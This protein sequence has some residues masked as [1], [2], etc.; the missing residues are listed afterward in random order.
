MTVFSIYIG[1]L[2]IIA[3]STNWLLHTECF[4]WPHIKHE[5]MTSIIAIRINCSKGK[6]R[7]PVISGLL[8]FFLLKAGVQCAIFLPTLAESWTKVD[9]HH[10]S[11]VL[12]GK[13]VI[14]QL[15]LL[16]LLN[17]QINRHTFPGA[18]N[19]SGGFHRLH[20]TSAGQFW[21]FGTKSWEHFHEII[22]LNCPV[23]HCL[24]N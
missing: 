19:I 22:W 5:A 20:R 24:A 17:L 1:H 11:F 8:A 9:N 12:C 23:A 6:H 3:E 13:H 15:F 18:S 4:T 10:F 16:F 14:V 7:A 21:F 2:T